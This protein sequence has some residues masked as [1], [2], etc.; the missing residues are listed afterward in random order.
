[1]AS[2]LVGPFSFLRP[3]L[4]S[5]APLLV[6]PYGAPLPVHK[7]PCPQPPPLPSHSLVHLLLTRWR[8]ILPLGFQLPILQMCC[9]FCVWRASS[10]TGPAQALLCLGIAAVCL[11]MPSV[12]LS[13][14]FFLNVW[15]WLDFSSFEFSLNMVA[16]K[17]KIS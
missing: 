2:R 5:L 4:P 17:F 11:L 6:T 3:I 16:F 13:V 7:S 10:T 14:F 9:P 12:I 15:A 1:M 8:P